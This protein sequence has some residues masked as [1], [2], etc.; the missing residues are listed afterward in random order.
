MTRPLREDIFVS[1]C[2][3]DVAL[4]TG[5][6]TALKGL[7]DKLAT[8][9][10]YWEILVISRDGGEEAERK[11]AEDRLLAAV[12]NIRLLSTRHA[13]PFYRKRLLLAAESIGD[14][15]LMTAIEEQ[16]CFEPVEMI[17]A[18]LRQ[19]SILV[20]RGR[21]GAFRYG[22]NPLLNSLGKTAGFHADARDMLTIA[23]P[24]TWLN[25]V[26]THSD[27]Q[28]ALRFPPIDSGIPVRWIPARE[29]KPSPL[30]PHDLQ[31]R[32]SLLQD[33]LI[34]AAPRVLTLIALGALMVAIASVLYLIYAIIVWL[35][36]AEVQEGWFSTSL[37][38]GLSA[39]FMAGATF[40]L[41]IGLHKVLRILSVDAMNDISDER[42][43]TDLFSRVL[44][45]LNVEVGIEDVA[46]LPD[47]DVA[48]SAP[49]ENESRFA[50][51]M[52]K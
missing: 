8:A 3:A 27:R 9:F 5:S 4:D 19:D 34:S 10:R 39:A 11:L 49:R 52:R 46:G 22:L 7:A 42:S 1:V 31:R 37:I 43:T 23:L 47:A 25:R 35:T 33:M 17:E 44:H 14:V 12:P 2:L 45:E 51:G 38:L 50:A 41:S 18:S 21:S 28:L 24:K 16:G 20:L 15:V 26:M 29:R 48:G 32:L 6:E 40:G 30:A 13:T 36:Y